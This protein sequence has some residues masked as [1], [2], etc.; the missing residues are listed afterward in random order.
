MPGF[1][2]AGAVVIGLNRYAGLA[3]WHCVLLMAAWVAKDL[4]LYP[5]VRTGYGA[6]ART[7]AARLVGMTGTAR[8]RLAPA[9]YV[10]VMGELWRASAAQ[11]QAPIEAGERVAIVGASRLEL[12]VERAIGPGGER[13]MNGQ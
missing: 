4:A 10:E 3:P 8:E 9:G 5:L 1:V 13:R 12:R 7:G 2:L 11:S 6:G